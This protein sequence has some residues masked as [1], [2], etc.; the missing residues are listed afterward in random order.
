MNKPE[1][2]DRFKE[3]SRLVLDNGNDVPP[4]QMHDMRICF[5]AGMVEM[6]AYLT[7]E[8]SKLP[9]AVALVRL[10]QTRETLT[11]ISVIAIK[12]GMEQLEGGHGQG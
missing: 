8:L 2:E 10:D 7:D 9:E 12:E 4:E 3:F 6:Y 1:F 11:T 5:I